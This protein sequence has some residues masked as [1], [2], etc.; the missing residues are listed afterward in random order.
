MSTDESTSAPAAAAPSEAAASE[1]HTR[2]GVHNV[3]TRDIPTELITTT[4]NPRRSRTEDDSTHDTNTCVSSVT[5]DNLSIAELFV[6][7]MYPTLESVHEASSSNGSVFNRSGGDDLQEHQEKSSRTEEKL[8]PQQSLDKDAILAE[9]DRM[10]RVTASAD[11]GQQ[12]KLLDKA[13][14]RQ[15]MDQLAMASVAALPPAISVSKNQLPLSKAGIVQELG[16]MANISAVPVSIQALQ[17]HLVKARLQ[18][19]QNHL[20]KVDIQAEMDRMLEVGP[21]SKTKSTDEKDVDGKKRLQYE[22]SGK[23]ESDHADVKASMDAMHATHEVAGDGGGEGQGQVFLA[24]STL[25]TGAGSTS[26]PGAYAVRSRNNEQ[27]RDNTVFS[28]EEEQSVAESDIPTASHHVEDATV[29]QNISVPDGNDFNA[30]ESID[31]TGASALSLPVDNSVSE[32]ERDEVF[33][34]KIISEIDRRPA[35]SRSNL[36]LFALFLACVAGVAVILATLANNDSRGDTTSSTLNETNIIDTE[37][38]IM[39]EANTAAPTL[40]V[41]APY[42][43][44]LP[45]IALRGI[46]NTGS[47]Y[48]EANRWMIEDPHRNTYS[49]QRQQQ[50]FY[51]AYYWYHFQGDNWF[52]QDHWMDYE[53]SECEWWSNTS[54]EHNEYDL[55]RPICDEDSNLLKLNLADNNLVGPMPMPGDFIISLMSFNVANNKISGDVSS[56]TNLPEL[57]VFIMS[58]NKLD[59]RNVNDGTFVAWKMRVIKTDGNMLFGDPGALF[60][61]LPFLEVLESSGNRYSAPIGETLRNNTNL[62]HLGNGD[63]LHVGTIPSSLGLLTALERIHFGGNIGMDGPIPSELGLLTALTHLNISHTAITG[64]VPGAL[65]DRVQ[66]NKLTFAAD[67]DLVTCCT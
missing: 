67:C 61:Y 32:Q 62:K 8:P 20:E 55:D 30:T 45:T 27:S 66:Q 9:M 51:M 5:M 49:E 36:V 7:H 17:G 2:L 59:G 60:Q 53:K 46:E 44:N 11:S 21:A 37:E 10:E 48:Y 35:R 56:S 43:D 18:T 57:D 13:G 1:L 3:R 54:P 63:S 65:C 50:R 22:M 38:G 41:Y 29:V 16:R 14:I 24:Q 34:A 6:D 39:E 52:H 12:Q 47:P 42:R 4:T 15:E 25:T 40:Q 28:M 64:N 26:T 19:E 31:R 33:D 58:N 23:S